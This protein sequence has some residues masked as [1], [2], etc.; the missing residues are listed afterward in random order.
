MLDTI[1]TMFVNEKKISEYNHFVHSQHET[2]DKCILR[3]VLWQKKHPPSHDPLK[4]HTEGGGLP[5][6]LGFWLSW[7][8]DILNN[9]SSLSQEKC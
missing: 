3:G 8:A 4:Y 5:P 7:T 2:Q 6:P 9:S 1:H